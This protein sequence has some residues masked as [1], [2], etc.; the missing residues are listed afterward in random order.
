MS[1]HVSYCFCGVMELVAG[2]PILWHISLDCLDLLIRV[3][4]HGRCQGDGPMCSSRSLLSHRSCAQGQNGCCIDIYTYRHIIM[5]NFMLN[6]TDGY[7]YAGHLSL[8]ICDTS[9]LADRRR[10]LQN[11][12][13]M[14]TYTMSLLNSKS[15][16]ATL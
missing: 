13:Q 6:L 9:L 10:E 16:Q 4:N 2:W 5:Y 1:L 11:L 12:A 15:R 14:A 7:L 3:G 8:T